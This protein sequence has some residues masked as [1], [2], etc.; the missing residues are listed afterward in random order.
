[1]GVTVYKKKT[2]EVVKP[3]SATV[4]ANA[5]NNIY[6]S[7]ASQT[8][9]QIPVGKHMDRIAFTYNG[10]PKCRLAIKMYGW[11]LSNDNGK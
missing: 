10:C 2:D 3:V 11:S 4:V 5:R 7:L 8:D 6:D 1:M 9:A